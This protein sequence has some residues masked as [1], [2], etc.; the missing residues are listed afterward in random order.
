MSITFIHW[1][2]LPT[3]PPVHRPAYTQIHRNVVPQKDAG[4]KP[5]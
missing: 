3:P 5:F 1:S 2:K 4:L